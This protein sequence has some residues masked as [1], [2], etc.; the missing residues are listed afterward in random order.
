MTAMDF[1]ESLGS[2]DVPVVVISGTRDQLISHSNTRRL[3]DLIEN[4][5]FEALPDFG[6]M[7]PL[8]TPDTV[9]DLLE[10]LAR[11]SSVTNRTE[12]TA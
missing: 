6:H 9:A 3:A 10:D 8:E 4:A 12:R 5:R 2:V 1:S 7:L 11:D